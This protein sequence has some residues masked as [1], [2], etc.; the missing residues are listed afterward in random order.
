M[1]DIKYGIVP[2][3][4]SN[5]E[6]LENIRFNAYKIDTTDF[7]VKDSF[8]F[9]K[10]QNKKY[11]VFGCYLNNE[12][13]GACYI[14]NSYNSLYIEQ[15]FILSEYQKSSYY[16]GTNLL[17]FVLDNKSVIEKHFNSKFYFSR[18]ENK[19]IDSNM[20]KSLGYVEQDFQMKKRI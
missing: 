16:L 2:L 20:Y 3:T 18:L 10:L 5:I 15:L 8:H 6:L 12:L 19:N 17:K 1:E 11:I 14:S 9:G 7:P 4:N 13:I